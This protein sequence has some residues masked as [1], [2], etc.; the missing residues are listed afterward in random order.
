[1]RVAIDFVSGTTCG[2]TREHATAYPESGGSVSGTRGS[3]LGRLDSVAGKH[4]TVLRS[5]WQ[6]AKRVSIAT[7]PQTTREDNACS[8]GGRCPLYA[9]PETALVCVLQLEM[10]A[11][12]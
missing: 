8:R 2:Y 4:V 10:Q 7:C 6:F 11:I 1:M 12:L 9:Q 5:T 3:V